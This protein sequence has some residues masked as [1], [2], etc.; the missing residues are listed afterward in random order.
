[1]VS[2]AQGQVPEWQWATGVGSGGDQEF[3]RGVVVAPDGSFYVLI[4]YDHD[5]LVIGDTTLYHPWPGN[6][7]RAMALAKY[8][9]SEGLLWVV[10]QDQARSC[11]ANA[12][13]VDDLGNVV[14][15]GSFRGGDAMFGTVVLDGANVVSD[16]ELFLVKISSEGLPLWGYS[17]GSPLDAD[18]IMD[19]AFDPA[20]N[21]IATGTIASSAWFGST[22]VSGA[23]GIPA[24]FIAKFDPNGT[25]SWALGSQGQCANSTRAVAADPTGNV[26]LSGRFF[27]T[28]IGFGNIDVYAPGINDDHGFLFKFDPDGVAIW[29]KPIGGVGLD[30][31]SQLVCNDAHDLY[32]Q[33]TVL[34]PTLTIDSLVSSV[35][36]NFGEFLAKF[37]SAGVV[38]WVSV[39]GDSLGVRGLALD[40]SGQPV[41]VGPL[42]VELQVVAGDT[43]SCPGEYGVF[44][45]T[46][47][48][49]G[50]PQW[51]LG[52]PGTYSL[53]SGKIGITP[54]NELYIAGSYTHDDAAF[55]GITLMHSQPSGPNYHDVFVAKLAL[56]NSPLEVAPRPQTELLAFPNP[57]DDLMTV[58]MG[59]SW[60]GMVTVHDAV[61]QIVHRSAR[62]STGT[63]LFIPT[64]DLSPGM[65]FL[66]LH[67]QGVARTVIFCVA[68]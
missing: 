59:A 27:N 24:T 54:D 3:G 64:G 22:L 28:P 68:H 41:V 20:G 62:M 8:D 30:E 18:Y 25:L 13:A 46:F 6:G 15:A 34:S 17:N 58:Q 11:D 16:A 50:T 36:Y 14:V 47:D 19:I 60:S 26:Y 61:G 65:Y 39:L 52:T 49:D 10:Q 7:H 9:N 29:G 42:K 37:D 44:V 63:S 57:T 32:I 35:P 31:V 67:G 45:I 12:L 43:L 21:V 51:A 55:G 48:Q 23:P 53:P 56:P 4:R 33:G 2:F 66:D 40:N 38:Q 1:M 5:S